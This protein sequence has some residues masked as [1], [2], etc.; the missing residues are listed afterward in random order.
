MMMKANEDELI[1]M[2]MKPDDNK[3]E[4]SVVIIISMGL[5]DNN[6]MCL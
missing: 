6:K 3:Y 1:M 2:T 4:Y 5:V